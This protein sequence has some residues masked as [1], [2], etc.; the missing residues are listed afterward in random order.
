MRKTTFLLPE[1][2]I[3]F[4]LV[5]LCVVPL[6]R[7][8][9]QIIC[10]EIERLE[11]LEKE[12]LADWTFSEVKEMFLKREIAWEKLPERGERTEN[13]PLPN[14]KIELPHCPPKTVRRSFYLTGRGFKTGLHSRK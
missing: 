13:I 8:P 9:M 11:E 1:I 6:V 14:A 5:T 4:F 3:A 7:Q 2:L 12:R 10:I